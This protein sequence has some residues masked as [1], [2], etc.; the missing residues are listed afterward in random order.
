MTNLT[1]K[2]INNIIFIPKPLSD[3]ITQEYGVA[4][5]KMK[6]TR[7]KIIKIKLDRA[8]AESDGWIVTMESHTEVFI[9]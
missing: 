8:Q 1:D 7:A 3:H 5:L 6:L 9:K 2:V 4:V